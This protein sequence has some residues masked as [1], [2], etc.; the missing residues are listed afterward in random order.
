MNRFYGKVGYS[1]QVEVRPGVWEDQIHEHEHYGELVQK[2]YRNQNVQ[3]QVH[4]DL[5]LDTDI[6]IIADAYAFE[7]F[8]KIRYICY[9][10]ARWVVTSVRVD[11]PR[12]YLTIGGIYNGPTAE[13]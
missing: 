4:D 12:L 6:E 2:R 7:H 13:N 11:H 9:G 8:S 3:D 1:N 10:G 5:R